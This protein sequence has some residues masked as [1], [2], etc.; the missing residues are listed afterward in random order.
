MVTGWKQID[1]DWYYFMPG[2]DG[3][4]VANT[5]MTIDGVS[6]TFNQD[7]TLQQ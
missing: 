1:G 6:Y 5:T 2:N 3:S 4:M 7:G